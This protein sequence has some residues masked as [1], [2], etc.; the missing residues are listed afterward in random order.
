MRALPAV[1]EMNDR[2]SE[3]IPSEHRFSE[4]ERRGLYRAIFDRRDVR[5]H[6]KSD[7][8]PNDVLARLLNAAH[9][10]PSVGFMQPWNFIVIQDAEVRR[11]IHDI[12]ERANRAA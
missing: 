2:L 1:P 6:F 4:C 5:S 3:N 9:H 8:I 11:T 10:A 7:P 12:F